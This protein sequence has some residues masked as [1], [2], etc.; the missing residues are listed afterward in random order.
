MDPKELHKISYNVD[1]H[2]HSLFSDGFASVEDSIRIRKKYIPNLEKI[3][4][5]DHYYLMKDGRWKDYVKEVKDLQEKDDFILLGLE[6][7]FSDIESKIIPKDLLDACDYI[8]VEEFENCSIESFTRILNNFLIGFNGTLIL[9]HPYFDNWIDGNTD[10]LYFV[11]EF[12]V[13][14]KIFIELNCST[15]YFIDRGLFGSLENV[16]ED[17]YWNEMSRAGLLP[18]L[19]IGTDTHEYYDE[20]ISFLANRFIHTRNAL[21]SLVKMNYKVALEIAKAGHLGQVDKAGRPYIYH[22]ME[23]ASMMDTEEE[24]ICAILHD[25][26]EDT[27]ISVDYLL[28]FGITSTVLEALH[29]LT[30]KKEESYMDYIKRLKLN[31]L[32]TKV[33]L[34]DLEHNLDI[35]RID[36]PTKDDINRVKKYKKAKKLL[37]T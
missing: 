27:R 13:D 21:K 6:V 10:S 5:S 34:C 14:Y 2:S 7:L 17:C 30:R 24:K 36:N 16:R 25:V 37:L 29:S 1:L 20:E 11:F 33:K 9:A 15:G 31:E 35:T 4:I 12:C 19:I 22:P 23:I 8:I 32:A 18:Y 28:E 3:G 26:L